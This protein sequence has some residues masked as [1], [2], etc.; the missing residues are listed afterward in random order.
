VS[1]PYGANGYMPMVDFPEEAAMDEEKFYSEIATR[2]KVPKE[3]AETVATAVL[4]E[5]HDR[6]NTKEANDIAAQL[7]GDL[8]RMWHVFDIPGRAVQRTHKR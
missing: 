2:L 5:L 1:L 7:P 8:K 6:L 3:Q 4:Q